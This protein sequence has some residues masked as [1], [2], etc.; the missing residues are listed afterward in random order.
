[1]QQSPAA[2]EIAIRN[3]VAPALRQ[4]RGEFA[5]ILRIY[6]SKLA[7]LRP[8]GGQEF[9]DLIHQR[10]EGREYRNLC[11]DTLAFFLPNRRRSVQSHWGKTFEAMPESQGFVLAL[12]VFAM[13]LLREN[14]RLRQENAALKNRSN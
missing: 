9:C 3:L 4:R 1:M 6:L 13:S 14:I 12:H 11:V 8:L 5:Q 10:G 2:V 7:T